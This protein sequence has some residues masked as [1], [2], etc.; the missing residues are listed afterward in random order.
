M[1][2]IR[3]ILCLPE[4]K[5]EEKVENEI[6]SQYIETS[7]IHGISKINHSKVSYFRIFWLVIFFAFVGSLSINS[8]KISR[9]LFA[10]E[11][12]TVESDSIQQGSMEFPTVTICNSNP[13]PMNKL[14]PLMREINPYVTKPEGN[15]RIK[16]FAET[17]HAVTNHLAKKRNL[18][19]SMYGQ[20]F[21]SFSA[22]QQ[23]VFNHKECNANL[24]Q[25]TLPE[26]GNCFVF[27]NNGHAR[28]SRPGVDFGFKI[29]VDIDQENYLPYSTS[30]YPVG[31]KL[32]INAAGNPTEK[33]IL[34]SPNQLTRIVIQKTKYHRLKSPYQDNCTDDGAGL[35]WTSGNYSVKSCLSWCYI[36]K[37]REECG[38]VSDSVSIFARHFLNLTLKFAETTEEISCIN[39]YDL[40]YSN[41]RFRCDC[42][43]LCEEVIYTT[44]VSTALWPS[45]PEKK[46]YS[47]ILRETFNVSTLTE[48]YISDNIV[49]IHITFEDFTVKSTIH[50]E[51]YDLT[52]FCSEL[53]GNFSLWIGASIFSLLEL[54]EFLMN[55]CCGIVYKL[56]C[57]KKKNKST[58][59]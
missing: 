17:F 27:N 47:Q 22:P 52:M 49:G 10:Y 3:K 18:N 9:K 51:A 28:Q 29:F 8:F 48:Q 21:Q 32:T 44:S 14:L 1:K 19:L 38:F 20:D 15:A 24:S 30:I 45:K 35:K 50:K 11:H 55:L 23:C 42:P 54:A 37:M 6:I 39:S 4:A 16:E 58:T 31:V 5:Q 26:G 13:Y 7:T 56:F 25:I 36:S 43:P 46:F 59:N 34:A 33:Q 40:A 53:G 2:I 41:G 57:G 12:V